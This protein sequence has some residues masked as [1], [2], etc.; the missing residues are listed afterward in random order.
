MARAVWEKS[1]VAQLKDALKAR[2]LP[3]AGKKDVL[4]NRL[5]DAESAAPAD[6]SPSALLVALLGAVL[7]GA[8]S[9]GFMA[10]ES[11]LS[12]TD[13]FYL[14][15]QTLSTVGYGDVYLENG[16]RAF[17]VLV[18]LLA[19]GLFC[20]PV[21]DLTS[22]WTKRV[23]AN[24][25]RGAVVIFSIVALVAMG[26][27]HALEGWAPFDSLYFAVI[28]GTT[29]GYG[30]H[31]P[32]AT[33]TGKVAA[34][35]FALF[36]VNAVGVVV[37]NASDALVALTKMNTKSS[38]SVALVGVG[39]VATTSAL[40]VAAQPGLSAVDAFYFSAITLS[41][42]GFGD[43]GFTP[44]TME[45]KCVV[46][47]AALL[48]GGFFCGPVLDLAASWRPATLRCGVLSAVA[49]AAGLCAASAALFHH[50]EGWAYDEGAYFAVI[51]GTT[52]G[53]GNHTPFATDSGKVAAGLF[54]LLTVSAMGL[55]VS[56]ISDA[57]STLIGTS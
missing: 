10:L 28:T 12:A 18:A 24:G 22:S 19:G 11:T 53:Y 31:T 34:A 29:I 36:A 14:S 6:S 39:I 48:A 5:V 33:D 17:A 7:L 37:S 57:L 47:L 16:S 15:V 45:A 51:T 4:V 44:T 42:V 20:G 32:F 46:I 35:I 50:L 9:L 3:A 54:A 55:V 13:A 27:F 23:G 49:L 56:T 40:L 26:L 52:I 1:T 41:T 25:V 8:T 2:G 30:D 43:E 38:A 21:L